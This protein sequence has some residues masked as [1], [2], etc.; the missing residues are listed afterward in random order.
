[1]KEKKPTWKPHTDK[2]TIISL[3]ARIGQ[4]SEGNENEI[5]IKKTLI[6]NHL[7]YVI[8]CDEFKNHKSMI[9]L[10]KKEKETVRE[11]NAE[12]KKRTKYYIHSLKAL[13][14]I[15]NTRC[16][17]DCT[18]LFWQ[19]PRSL[20]PQSSLYSFLKIH[21]VLE[22]LVDISRFGVITLKYYFDDGSRFWKRLWLEVV[23]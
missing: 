23:Y 17:W 14:Y 13:K 5:N 3:A 6:W 4:F 10:L 9:A 7:F 2:E 12:S 16:I 8:L 11:E 21:A 15:S 19:S 20:K 18:E 22:G 1:M